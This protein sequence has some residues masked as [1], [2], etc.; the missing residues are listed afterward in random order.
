MRVPST[1]MTMKEGTTTI[2]TTTLPT[3]TSTLTTT[4]TSPIITTSV[5]THSIK[6]KAKK[7]LET[8]NS[9]YNTLR[10]MDLYYNFDKDLIFP[11]SVRSEIFL[12]AMAKEW[13]DA[14]S[15][16][17]FDQLQFDKYRIIGTINR[18]LE[19]EYTLFLHLI[20]W[21]RLEKE[22]PLLAKNMY[23]HYR[24]S[25]IHDDTKSM[26]SLLQEIKD[27]NQIFS[28]NKHNFCM[29]YLNL[30]LVIV[31]L[32]LSFFVILIALTITG[33][34]YG[35]LH[36]KNVKRKRL[37]STKEE[38]T[39]E[40]GT[41]KKEEPGFTKKKI[42]ST[43]KPEVKS[44]TSIKTVEEVYEDLKGSLSDSSEDD[45]G[46]TIKDVKIKADVHK[47]EKELIGVNPF[48]LDTEDDIED[49]IKRMRKRQAEERT[50]QL[51]L[52]EGRISSL[53]N[54]IK[55]YEEEMEPKSGRPPPKRN[56]TLV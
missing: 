38:E 46:S 47:E 2:S 56:E 7:I 9:H 55:R 1:M 18:R 22:V 54:E 52:I 40:L 45:D 23:T 10:K 35:K 41:L 34:K 28:L 12:K 24:L 39:V 21:E 25:M 27:T 51:G 8:E 26:E 14:Q 11:S 16:G 19:D 43:I 5:G 3:S 49:E 29:G 32:I 50:E 33:Y 42:K 17:D 53:V 4:T 20:G 37:S 15:S 30:T 31:G 44:M 13:R 48:L 6:D 36:Y